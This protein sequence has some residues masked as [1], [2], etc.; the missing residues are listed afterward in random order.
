MLQMPPMNRLL[1][2]IVAILA[3]VDVVTLAA[4]EKLRSRPVPPDLTPRVA[5]LET[6]LSQAQQ[7][8]GDL[9]QEVALLQHRG[10]AAD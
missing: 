1:P 5:Q 2:L 6:D 10:Q 9:K 7:D 8:I 3:A 4:V